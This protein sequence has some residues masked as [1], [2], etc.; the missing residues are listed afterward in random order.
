[1]IN[2]DTSMYTFISIFFWLLI[3]G[4]TA[5]FAKQRGRDPVIWFLVGIFFGL[6]GLL[7]L[8]ILPVASDQSQLAEQAPEVNS[9]AS[10]KNEDKPSLPHP[11]PPDYLVKD[12]FYL[13]GASKQQGPV[14]FDTLRRIWQEGKIGWSSYVWCEGMESWKRLEELVDLKCAL[15]SD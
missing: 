13:D 11:N 9:L 15:S 12:W 10:S 4:A 8:F 6:L 5:H 1:M 3:G 2:S 14:T 7:L